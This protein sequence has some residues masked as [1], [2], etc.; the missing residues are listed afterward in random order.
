MGRI[1]M[2]RFWD[3]RARE[4]AFY[5]VDNRLDYGS[6]DQIVSGP[7]VATHSTKFWP[8]WVPIWPPKTTSWRSAAVSVE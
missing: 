1:D 7:K 2:K 5:F 4:D 8:R 3:D 6:P